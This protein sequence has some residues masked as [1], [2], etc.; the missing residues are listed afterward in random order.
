MA[1]ELLLRTDPRFTHIL[2]D[3]E[4]SGAVKPFANDK[5]YCEAAELS[6]ILSNIHHQALRT[7]RESIVGSL[8]GNGNAK[9][10]DGLLTCSPEHLSAQVSQ[11]KTL[12]DK[13]RTRTKQ[14]L[15]T[16]SADGE[17][18]FPRVERAAALYG[19]SDQERDALMLLL[20]LQGATSSLWCIS[21]ELA[22]VEEGVVDARLLRCVCGMSAVESGHLMD[23]E[24]CHAKEGIMQVRD[25]Q[26][27][28]GKKTICLTLE[29][30][31][32]LTHG[33]TR[34]SNAVDKA[35]AEKLRLK[36]SGTKLLEMLEK[37]DPTAGHPPTTAIPL[38]AAG[39]RAPE[40]A[41]EVEH[42]GRTDNSAVGQ[43]LRKLDSANAANVG[44]AA[45]G[46]SVQSAE[47]EAEAA[48]AAAMTQL[49]TFDAMGET[50]ELA[51]TA[52][53]TGMAADAMP[54]DEA[55]FGDGRDAVQTGMSARLEQAEMGVGGAEAG[56][57]AG[58]EEPMRGYDCELEYLDDQFQCLVQR[59]Q[60][61]S[62]LAKQRVKHMEVEESS[63]WW[64]RGPRTR[65]N[66]SELQAKVRM[67]EGKISLRLSRDGKLGTPRLEGLCS[68]LRLDSFE[69]SVLLLAC[70]RL[71]RSN[72]I[73][74][75]RI[76]SNRRPHSC[77]KPQD[78]TADESD[79]LM[80]A[81]EPLRLLVD[82]DASQGTRSRRWSSSCS[83][84][85]ARGGCMT[86]RS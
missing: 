48:V 18:W 70:G 80:T 39:S 6:L 49:A 10:A 73:E 59:I 42:M 55:A 29:V 79:D 25:D 17:S 4:S 41:A 58:F 19:L 20:L 69:K 51:V 81:D 72:L 86:P 1:V 31:E 52:V 22:D 64:E 82:I 27:T 63:S 37:E 38:T 8:S 32:A 40:A 50:D 68:Q 26:L 46:S 71:P 67:T 65:V 76:E 12:L 36:L 15:N 47:A 44:G 34:G 23:E 84:R 16:A 2:E 5:E 14:R 11:I 83:R 24:R 60:L 13:M 75:N 66:T 56:A 21:S 78:A 7:L 35:R 61:S 85:R 9:S 74:P 3:V 43:L 77:G 57:G 30:V 53:A 54:V 45:M 28:P 62:E 33:I